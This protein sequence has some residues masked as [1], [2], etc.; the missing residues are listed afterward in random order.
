MVMADNHGPVRVAENDLC[1]HVD[2]AVDKK[3]AALEHFLMDKH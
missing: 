3:E 2:K 1:S